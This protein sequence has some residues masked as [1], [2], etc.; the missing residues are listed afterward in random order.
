MNP[1]THTQPL[2]MARLPALKRIQCRHCRTDCLQQE[3]LC[4]QCGAR[5][6]PLSIEVDGITFDDFTGNL[7]PTAPRAKEKTSHSNLVSV[8]RQKRPPMTAT[9]RG[10]TTLVMQAPSPVMRL[11][12]CKTCGQQNDEEAHE[13]RK[14]HTPLEIVPVGSVKEI[15]PLP[16]AWGFDLLGLAWLL[17]GFLAV[18]GN[19][20]LIKSNGHLA[21]ATWTDYLWSGIVVCAPGLFIFMRHYFCKALFGV[22]S[23]VSQ[24]VWSVIGVLW[25]SGHLYVSENGQVGLMWLAMLSGLVMVSHYTVCQNDAFDRE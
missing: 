12:F 14:C 4:W 25:M 3:T 23:L 22:M 18:Y 7:S 20:F 10:G 17:L 1:L 24:L 19:Q 21:G 2:N 13:C 9:K 8:A 16:R 6:H 5:L 11:S 15:Q